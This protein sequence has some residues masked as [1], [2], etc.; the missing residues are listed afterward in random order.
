MLNP[1]LLAGIARVC[2]VC[3]PG[4][5]IFQLRPEWRE[6]GVQLSH[7]LCSACARKLLEDAQNDLAGL[8]RVHP[9]PVPVDAA[10]RRSHG[11]SPVIH[12]Q[13]IAA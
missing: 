13:H 11:A 12:S 9:S 3:H 1:T 6:A 5:S 10:Q 8:A 7:G 4:D 2:C